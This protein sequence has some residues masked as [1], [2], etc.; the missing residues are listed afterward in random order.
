MTKPGH[1]LERAITIRARPAA[2]FTVSSDNER[3]AFWRGSGST[4]ETRPGGQVCICGPNRSE[5][6][7]DVVEIAPPATPG[8]RGIQLTASESGCELDLSL[9]FSAAV[10]I[11]QHEQAWRF[12]LASL[13]S[14]IS[15]SVCVD[16]TSRI[17]DWFTVWTVLDDNERRTLAARVVTP[18]IRFRYRDSLLSGVDDLLAYI[19]PTQQWMPGLRIWREGNVKHCQDTF[20]ARWTDASNYGK[21]QMA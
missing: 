21:I 10:P 3:W 14:L 13:A 20:R 11:E 2:V 19:G 18:G 17:D 7:G 5:F 16:A 6:V 12:Q 9:E 15:D 4:I 8:S 1:H